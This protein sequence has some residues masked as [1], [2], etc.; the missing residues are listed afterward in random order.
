MINADFGLEVLNS[1]VFNS[2]TQVV[3]AVRMPRCHG[4]H[5]NSVGKLKA[6]GQA[7]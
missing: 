5:L 2:A 7:G 4:K 3:M 1:F 6:L